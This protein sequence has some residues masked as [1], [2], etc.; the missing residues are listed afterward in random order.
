MTKK[1]PKRPRPTFAAIAEKVREEVT[2]EHAAWWAIEKQVILEGAR[3][4]YEQA[5]ALLSKHA[6]AMEMENAMLRENLRAAQDS[7]LA[8][9]GSRIRRIWS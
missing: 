3:L 6:T 7:W 1:P 2:E 5:Y 8:A 9:L 4:E